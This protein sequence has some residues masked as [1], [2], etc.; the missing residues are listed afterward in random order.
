MKTRSISFCQF[1][2]SHKKED[3]AFGDLARDLSDARR[4]SIP[5]AYSK[6]YKG[7]KAHMEDQR[8]CDAALECLQEAHEAYQR[9]Q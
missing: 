4:Y 6:T 1:I 7:I 8:A 3:S 2:L 5:G 9:L